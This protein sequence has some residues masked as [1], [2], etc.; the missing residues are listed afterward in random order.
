M[1]KINKNRF[2]SFGGKNYTVF[3]DGIVSMQKYEEKRGRKD[4]SSGFITKVIG[5]I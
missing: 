3:A 5:H 2:Y 4:K 1:K